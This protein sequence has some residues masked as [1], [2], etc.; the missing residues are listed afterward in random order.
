MIVTPFGDLKF[1]DQRALQSWA[2]A[3]DLRHRAEIQA[4]IKSQGV[5]L[6]YANLDTEV[7]EDWHHRH[8]TYHKG[9]LKFMAHD[10]SKSAQLLDTPWTNDDNFQFWHQMHDEL[11]KV[12]DKTLGI[13]NA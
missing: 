8:F 1:G 3:H 5:S 6:G 11:H 2:T 4:I 10:S 12:L 13:S 9:M 7:D